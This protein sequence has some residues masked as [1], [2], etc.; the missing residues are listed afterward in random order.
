MWRTPDKSLAAAVI[1]TVLVATVEAQS[2]V[3]IVDGPPP[4]TTL[5]AVVSDQARVQLPSGIR[6]NVSSVERPIA[7]DAVSVV[8]DRV[9]LPTSTAQVRLAVQA[10]TTGFTPPIAGATTWDASDVSWT[11]G[12]WSNA[13]G[14]AG[15]LSPTTYSAI[16]TCHPDVSS[17]GTEELVFTLAAKPTVTSAGNH[18][19]A[20]VWK[21]EAL[22]P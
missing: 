8:L 9:V 22:D 11:A 7:S 12:Q 19:L 20:I 3:H 14:G 6:F 13:A 16:A 17:C 1:S 10:A 5:S 18:T 4:M 15:T 21:V 2:T